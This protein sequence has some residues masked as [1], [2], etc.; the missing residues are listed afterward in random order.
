MSSKKRIL[1]EGRDDKSHVK[2]LLDVLHGGHKVKIDTAEDIKGIC[3]VTAS[4]NKAKIEAV[5]R[6]CKEST[7]HKNLYYLCDREYVNFEIG[8]KIVDL[9][10]EHTLNGNL[11]L[12]IG[13]SIE[14]YF[15]TEDLLCE[16][17]RYHCGSAYKSDAVVLFRKIL[18]SA[19]KI[20]AIS[21][22]AAKD[23][24][25]ASFP[26]GVIGWQ[27]FSFDNDKIYFNFTSWNSKNKTE[28]AVN[29]YE[30][31]LK[32]SPIV[33]QTDE[34]I[35]SRICRGHTAMLLLQRIF[36]AC[37]HQVIKDKDKLL[38]E[39]DAKLFSIIKEKNLSNA[40]CESWI[41]QAK[42]GQSVYPRE[43]IASVA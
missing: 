36:S 14:N 19:I 16:A 15:F 11:A 27:D 25:R 37:L 7:T 32:I 9:M 12:T 29:F 17:Y 3:K 20:V 33:E 34:V 21:A 13:H 22:L 35:C 24:G 6:R 5:F 23:I 41:K 39:N 10:P 4:N 31:Y 28:I 8:T 38:A 30:S 26:L 18:P 42:D 2:N 43:L 1:V 40:L